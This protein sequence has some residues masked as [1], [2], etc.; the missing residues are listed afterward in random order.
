MTDAESLKEWTLG[1]IKHKDIFEKKIVKIEDKKDGFCVHRKDAVQN[2]AVSENFS[3]G[4]VEETRPGSVPSQL[5]IVC[6]N[7]PLNVKAVVKDWKKLIK[8]QRLTILFVNLALGEK[9]MLNPRVHDMIADSS[10]LESGLL[11][12]MRAANGVVDEEP[13]RKKKSSIFEESDEGEESPEDG[14]E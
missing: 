5:T 14:D 8:H 9:W 11:N 10:T 6:L 12:L 13:K 2:Y 1:F 3:P 7:N 4:S